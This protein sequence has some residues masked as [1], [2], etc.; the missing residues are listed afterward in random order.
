[1]T[2][3]VLQARTLRYGAARRIREKLCATSPRERVRLEIERLI[4]GGDAGV[5]YQHAGPWPRT[6]PV[7]RSSV[8]ACVRSEYLALLCTA[9]GSNGRRIRSPLPC[10]RGRTRYTS[11][12]RL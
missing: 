10:G 1:M 3:G 2:H 4:L 5:S 9:R 12:S 8:V 6:A 11:P 7:A